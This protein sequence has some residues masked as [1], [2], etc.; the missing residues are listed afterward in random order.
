MQFATYLFLTSFYITYGIGIIILIGLLLVATAWSINKATIVF[1]DLR[2]IREYAV[3]RVSFKT[4]LKH[5]HGNSEIPK[6]E[7][8]DAI[9]KQESEA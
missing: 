7:A 1:K 9:P 3:Y 2:I 8:K 6:Q 5:I 4:Y